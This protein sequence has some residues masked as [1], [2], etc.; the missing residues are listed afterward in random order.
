MLFHSADS[1]RK[2]HDWLWLAL[3]AMVVIMFILTLTLHG[4]LVRQ[5]FFKSRCLEI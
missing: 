2:P 1:K 5:V 4:F 3:S